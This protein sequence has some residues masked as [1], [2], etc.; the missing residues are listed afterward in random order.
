MTFQS[1]TCMCFADLRQT[2]L[3]RI[4][5]CIGLCMAASSATWGQAKKLPNQTQQQTRADTTAKE[6]VRIRF[7]GVFENFLQ[8]Q[9]TIVKLRDEVEIQQDSVYLFCDS[10]TVR[11]RR[12]VTASGN[13]ILKHGDSTLIYSDSATYRGDLRV[14][15]LFG[16]VAMVSGRQKLFTDRLTYDTRSKIASYHTGATLTDDT[17]FITSVHGYFHTDTE[18]MFFKDSVRVLSTDFSLKSDTLRFDT[19]N[20]VVYFPGPTLILMDTARIYTESGFYKINEKRAQFTRNPQYQKNDQR[21]WARGM[22]Y[23]GHT[24]EVTLLVDAHFQDSNTVANAQYIRHNEKTG[25]TVLAGGAFIQ[26]ADRLLRGDTVVYDAKKGTYSTRG[27]SIIYDGPQILQA[28]WVDYDKERDVGLARGNVIWRDTT[29]RLTVVCENAEHASNRNYLKAHGGPRGR[30]LLMKMLEND[31]LFLSADTLLSYEIVSPDSALSKQLDPVQAELPQRGTSTSKARSPAPFIASPTATPDTASIMPLFQITDTTA[32][33]LV[34]PSD[35]LPSSADSLGVDNDSVHIV[36]PAADT[37][38]LILAFHDVRIFKS[39]MQALCDSLSY[40]TADSTF[41]LFKN[42]VIWSDSSQFTADTV[43][44]QLAND[45][46]DKVHL[47]NNSFIVNTPDE[48]FFNQI[49]GRNSTAF[50]QEGQLHHVRVSGNAESIYYALDDD[51]AYIGVN[52]AECSEML[53]RFRDDRVDEIV[54]YTQPKATLLPMKTTDHQALKLK[55]FSWRYSERP[56]S[57][58]DLFDTNHTTAQKKQDEN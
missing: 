21:A 40:S 56:R 9:D 50:F 33:L 32:R 36:Q 41:S 19:R 15:E 24:G 2:G 52:K 26:D 5:L 44:M 10:A 39:D 12:F 45:R 18:E 3:L 30:P 13:F 38:R 54:F 34:A 25:I 53:I 11:N 6:F 47:R 35:A 22:L 23:D 37:F 42:P 48:I 58:D 14:A 43:H 55:G 29:E 20:K 4:V 49:K 46:I 31:T 51:D 28:E 7:A 27:R 57:V 1:H 16:N 8:G 17:T